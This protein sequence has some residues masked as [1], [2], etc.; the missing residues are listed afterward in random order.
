[1]AKTAQ[2]SKSWKEQKKR[3]RR[4]R[5]KKKVNV[6]AQVKCSK[7]HVLENETLLVEDLF[8]KEI[9]HEEESKNF[10]S[11]QLT[12]GIDNKICVSF[13]E[14]E[15]EKEDE[16]VRLESAVIKIQCYFKGH[17]SRK[18]FK[19]MLRAYRRK[20]KIKQ[21]PY[22]FNEEEFII[23]DFSKVSRKQRYSA[24][25]DRLSCSDTTEASGNTSE[26]VCN[27]DGYSSDFGTEHA[28]MSPQ[29]LY[30]PHRDCTSG[31]WSKTKQKVYVKISQ[32]LQNYN[33]DSSSEDESD[34]E[35]PVREMLKSKILNLYE[36]NSEQLNLNAI[37]WNELKSSQ[38]LKERPYN[39]NIPQNTGEVY[40]EFSQ[41][42]QMM[43]FFAQMCQIPPLANYEQ[44]NNQYYWN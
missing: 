40:P 26:H 34:S 18:A 8:E 21:F 31:N 33:L 24:S 42:H 4:K 11:H 15:E 22:D 27:S 1:M 13:E 16:N 39:F 38:E 6:E 14:Q 41:A 7:N 29:K 28:N 10:L 36:D 43:S 3:K 9:E 5:Q 32:N 2:E 20:I 44:R 37:Q 19:G 17:L 23:Y 35:D 12:P 25:V 30:D